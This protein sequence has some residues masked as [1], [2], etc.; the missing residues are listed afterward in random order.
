MCTP[1]FIT[2]I[3]QLSHDEAVLVMCLAKQDLQMTKRNGSFG[4]NKAPGTMFFLPNI[5]PDIDASDVPKGL[6]KHPHHMKMYLSHLLALNLVKIKPP[7][8]V[9]GQTEWLTWTVCPTDFGAMF[10]ATCVAEARADV[11]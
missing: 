10:I 3:E 4:T 6:V 5:A 9:D 1:A 7:P 11:V 8:K 2:V